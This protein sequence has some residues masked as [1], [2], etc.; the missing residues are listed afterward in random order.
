MLR[1]S[2]L[3]AA[4]S[5]TAGAPAIAATV[6]SREATTPV[7]LVAKDGV[8]V[9]ALSYRAARPKALILLFHQAGSGKGEYATIAP[10]LAALGYSALA[11]DQ[12]SG[13]GLFGPN[14]TAERLG[15]TAGYLE[16]KRDLDAAL[17]W[18]ERQHLP[19]ILWGSSYSAALVFL[20]AAEHPGAVR[21]VIAYS[22]GEYLG[23][24]ALVHDA[25]RR[26]HAPIYVSS[27]LNPAEIRAAG[28]ILSSSPAPIKTQ[29]VPRTGGVHG[30]STL[31]PSHNPVGAKDN[32]S[33]VTGFLSRLE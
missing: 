14:E 13:G 22:P 19:V 31:I 5:M 3:C 24:P 8:R 28:S 2:I 16:T 21:A 30:S 25:A 10:R 20:V 4:L 9:Y 33:A 26:I 7:T 11:I 29:Y 23:S 17:V 6:Q 32:W 1:L 27:A 12:R 15:R 18:G